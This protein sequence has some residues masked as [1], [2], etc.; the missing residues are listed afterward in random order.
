MRQE[1]PSPRETS[2]KL[3]MKGQRKVI[4]DRMEQ[5]LPLGRNARA[6]ATAFL[7]ARK[8]SAFA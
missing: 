2:E 1:T 4:F 5:G 6:E 8:R 3:A 7:A